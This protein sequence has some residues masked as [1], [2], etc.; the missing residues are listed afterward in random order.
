MNFTKTIKLTLLAGSLAAA[1]LTQPLLVYAE[2]TG[3]RGGGGDSIVFDSV[4]AVAVKPATTA[5]PVADDVIVD[6]RIITAE[7]RAT[8]S[9]APTGT[10]AFNGRLLTA[11]DLRADQ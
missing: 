2:A 8:A 10:N 7:D 9:A 6:G 11:A 4:D 3:S 1:L 5:A